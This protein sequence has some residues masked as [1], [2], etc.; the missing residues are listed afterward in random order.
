MCMC[1]H[2]WGQS[3][4]SNYTVT[5]ITGMGGRCSSY[6]AI[7]NSWKFSCLHLKRVWALTNVG[8]FWIFN[9]VQSQNTNNSWILSYF[10]FSP[11]RGVK[12]LAK[13]AWLK[14]DNLFLSL[15][16]RALSRSALLRTGQ[17]FLRAPWNLKNLSPR[18]TEICLVINKLKQGEQQKQNTNVL[19]ALLSTRSQSKEHVLI[20]SGYLPQVLGN[21]TF[22]IQYIKKIQLISFK[23]HLLSTY[24]L[25]NIMLDAMDTRVRNKDESLPWQHSEC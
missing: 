4:E 19:N 13:Y 6:R 12:G 3:A 21:I 1:V 15:K 25:T 17:Q 8:S 20:I 18:S 10:L 24:R 2:S 5:Q 14:K 9:F 22:K 23:E 7:T 16:W 11:L